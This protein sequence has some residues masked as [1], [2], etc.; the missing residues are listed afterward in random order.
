MPKDASTRPAPATR[1]K[2]R[3]ATR[4]RTV[5]ASRKSNA[6]KPVLTAR[7]ADRHTLYQIAVQA[8]DAE[9]DFVGATFKKLRG[10]PC[11][12]IREDFCGTAYSSCEW[13]SR[14]KAH[15]AVGL[16]LHGPT[17]AWGTRNNL[18]KLTPE[19]RDRVKLI[20]AN[21]LTPPEEATGIDA[22]LAMNFSYFCFQ[23]R[24]Q[25]RAYFTRV[26]ESLAPDGVFFMDA[27][28][29]YESMREQQERRRCKGGFTYIW[30]QATYDPITGDMICHIH[31]EFKKGPAMKKAFSYRWRLW[32]LPEIQELLLEAGFKQ[33]T[34]HWEGE[35]KK[36]AGNGVFTPK[37]HGV[38]DASFICY[39]TALP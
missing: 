33:P 31:F 1:T 23:T 19:Q 36:G 14:G 16:D 2:K 28:G 12:S 9:M 20:K 7:T 29:G 21:V 22:V 6:A 27:W 34:V 26:R 18:A 39:I 25:M 32:T 11:V 4:T 30:D 38:A 17:L 3:S 15:T 24:E 8:P 35:D 5:A 37:K 13:V 10:R